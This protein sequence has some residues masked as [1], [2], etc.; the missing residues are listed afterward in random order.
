MV[1]DTFMVEGAQLIDSI[2]D[3]GNIDTAGKGLGS[4]DGALHGKDGKTVGFW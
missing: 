2:G 1:G 3:V 4:N